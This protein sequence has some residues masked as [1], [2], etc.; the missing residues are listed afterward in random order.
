MD[1]RSQPS[2]KSSDSARR[3]L[4]LN[5]THSVKEE[6]EAPLDA[7]LERIALRHSRPEP[8][9][10]AHQYAQHDREFVARDIGPEQPRLLPPRE[11]AVRY[12][13]V[14]AVVLLFVGVGKALAHAVGKDRARQPTI[15]FRHLRD[16]QKPGGEQF[17]GGSALPPRWPGLASCTDS[18]RKFSFDQG[19]KPLRSGEGSYPLTRL[20]T[21]SPGLAHEPQAKLR[22]EAVIND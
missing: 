9:N 1:T 22:W 20:A 10:G 2:C 7:H 13:R 15:G 6:A 17:I 4:L 8:D 3:L 16:A 11:D 5:S 19:R 12:R 21:T 14:L 18:A